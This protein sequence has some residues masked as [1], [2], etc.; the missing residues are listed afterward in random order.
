MLDIVVAF[1]ERLISMVEY[2][3]EKKK[4]FSVPTSPL[5]NLW[6]LPFLPS[7][8]PPFTLAIVSLFCRFAG[9]GIAPALDPSPTIR[10]GEGL[11]RLLRPAVPVFTPQPFRAF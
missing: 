8:F 9:I 1:H 7:S 4:Y 3:L 5:Y 6:V 11:G 10:P 2:I